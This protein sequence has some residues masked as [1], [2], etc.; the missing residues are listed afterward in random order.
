MM[1]EIK[2]N[3]SFQLPKGLSVQRF[4]QLLSGFL[5]DKRVIMSGS[6]QTVDFEDAE[7]IE[8]CTNVEPTEA[9]CPQSTVEDGQQ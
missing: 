7:I 5:H 1:T 6:L 8:E 4:I 3:G 2:F 9:T